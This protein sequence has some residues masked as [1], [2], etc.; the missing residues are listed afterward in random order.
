[1]HTHKTNDETNPTNAPPTA[2]PT[3]PLNSNNTYRFGEKALARPDI[4]PT[5]S[6]ASITYIHT[7]NITLQ[8]FFT[9]ICYLFPT[10]LVCNYTPDWT[11]NQISNKHYLQY[12]TC[13]TNRTSLTTVEIPRKCLGGHELVQ[14]VCQC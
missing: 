6:I 3:P 13:L 4:K 9:T 1:M 7:D 2:N 11:T 8:Q 10:K 14:I 5:V 12:V